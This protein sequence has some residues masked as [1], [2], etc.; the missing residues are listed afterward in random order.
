MSKTS[1]NTYQYARCIGSR[2]YEKG[3]TAM[4]MQIRLS[5]LVFAILMSIG[6]VAGLIALRPPLTTM[7]YVQLGAL[8]AGAGLIVTLYNA[9]MTARARR[10][11]P[12]SAPAAEDPSVAAVDCASVDATPAYAQTREN[13]LSSPVARPAVAVI[14][15]AAAPAE[16]MLPESMEELL[17]V[18]YESAENDPALAIAAYRRAL[19]RYPNDSYMPYLIIELSTLYKRM[20]NYTA[21]LALFD[22]ALAL[23]IITQNAVMVQELKRS[24][25]ALT[26]VSHML[27]AQGTPTLPF[28][29][30]PK[31]ILAEAD[32]RADEPNI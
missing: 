18:A 12:V 4:Q 24:R 25:R 20:G 6:V 31:E 22:E 19:A 23:P 28:G 7:Y 21:A 10:R 29:E 11:T 26:V 5:S 32:R 2:S 17:D 1:R 16:Q 15:E 8:V 27:A 9:F 13:A 30:V 3:A 14:Q